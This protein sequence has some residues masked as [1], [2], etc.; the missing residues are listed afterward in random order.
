MRRL[1][2]RIWPG[3][4]RLAALDQLVAGR[5][6]AHPHPAERPAPA[7][8][9]CWPA[10]R[11][12]RAVSTV[13]AAKTVGRRTRCRRRRRAR[14]SPGRRP[15]RRTARRM[16]SSPGPADSSTMTTASAPGGH[17]RTGH[18]AH[19]LARAR[20]EIGG[21]CRQRIVPITGSRLGDRRAPATSA[22]RTAKPSTA[23]W[24][25]AAPI[26][27]AT[28]R[29]RRRTRGR[30]RSAGSRSTAARAGAEDVAPGPPRRAITTRPPRR[31]SRAA[32]RKRAELR[33]EVL[34]V[35]RPSR[36]WPAGS[37]ACC[38]CRSARRRSSQP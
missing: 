25:T 30:R 27:S 23:C 35:E 13:P 21:A 9:R 3:R 31:G 15:R 19:R 12:G 6:H 10:R 28:T 1:E 17:R 36:R 29:R 5:Q 8:P 34:A 18:D 22:A 20:P 33:P 11:G 37:R 38:R 4:Q 32:A 24:R 7:R 16:P 14:A 2:S 26:R